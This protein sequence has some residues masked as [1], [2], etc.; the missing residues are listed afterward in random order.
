MNTKELVKPALVIAIILIAVIADRSYWQK[1]PDN[2][3][4]S[5]ASPSISAGPS[6]SSNPE[7]S[8][9]PAA[10]EPSGKVIYWMNIISNKKNYKF[11]HYC[12]GLVK[13]YKNDANH[14]GL[15]PADSTYYYCIGRNQL[16]LNLDGEMSLIK[17]EVISEDKNAP[18][19]IDIKRLPSDKILISYS[20]IPCI[21]VN[22]CTVGTP[23]NYATIE[24]NLLDNT[25]RDIE[26]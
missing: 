8:V 13:L 7:V 17:D 22:D 1:G 15:V 2:K 14:S 25:F 19:L 11:D 10:L 21:T 26:N 23:S 16:F 5:E 18:L 4:N 12:D 20:A 24:F 6:V 3:Q 9:A